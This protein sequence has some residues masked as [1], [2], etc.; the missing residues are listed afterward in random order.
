MPTEIVL[1]HGVDIIRVKWHLEKR[2]RVRCTGTFGNNIVTVAII[3][4]TE[5]F[6]A[7]RLIS[8]K[9]LMPL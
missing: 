8:D 9:V 7:A 2:Q 6:G 3:I 1:G 4:T 5:T